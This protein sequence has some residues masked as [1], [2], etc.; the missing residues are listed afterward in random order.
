VAK[1]IATTREERQVLHN[2]GPVTWTAGQL[3]VLA[4]NGASRLAD[5]EVVC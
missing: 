3:K 2:N 5:I 4:V 1:V